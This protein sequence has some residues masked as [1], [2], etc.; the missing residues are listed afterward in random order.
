MNAAIHLPI[1][2]ISADKLG[3]RPPAWHA[4]AKHVLV[5]T[6]LSM[7]GADI[8]PLTR[9][10][11][12]LDAQHPLPGFQ[13]LEMLIGGRYVGEIV[14]LVLGEGVTDWG[15]CGGSMPAGLDGWYAL[16]TETVAR[17][18]GYVDVLS[19]FHLSLLTF[20]IHL[21]FPCPPG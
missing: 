6:E 1:S 21:Y 20:S 18:E 11:R 9:W 13:P 16:D 8:W 19:W 12:L 14:R 10:D 3:S 7:F 5:N 15:L 2:S 17:L 4:A